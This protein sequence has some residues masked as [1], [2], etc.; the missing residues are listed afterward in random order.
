MLLEND[1]EIYTVSRGRLT[2]TYPQMKN[3]LIRNT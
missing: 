3:Q 2:V 1:R